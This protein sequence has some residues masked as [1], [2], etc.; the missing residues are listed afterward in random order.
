[1]YLDESLFDEIFAG[2]VEDFDLFVNEYRDRMGSYR[3]GRL[4]EDPSYDE[5]EETVDLGMALAR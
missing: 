2:Q 1:M 4:E 5:Y 3:C